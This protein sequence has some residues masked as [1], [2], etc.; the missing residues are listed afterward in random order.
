MLVVDACIWAGR[1][2]VGMTK[3]SSAR[4]IE[5]NFAIS[6]TRRMRFVLPAPVHGSIDRP[7]RDEKMKKERWKPYYVCSMLPS[8]RGKE[9]QY[10]PVAPSFV[11]AQGR[12]QP[13][14]PNEGGLYRFRRIA[15][16]NIAI[17]LSY[18]PCSPPPS[19]LSLS[20]S[21]HR[22]DAHRCEYDAI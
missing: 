3:L 14:F 13:D 1:R 18:R 10:V 12:E 16:E 7:E 19:L 4:E 2:D 21:L 6:E 8:A 11:A 15:G 5:Q 20:L 9:D 22:R 17:F